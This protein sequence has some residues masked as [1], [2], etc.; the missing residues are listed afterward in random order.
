[1]RR[2]LHT[3]VEL[4]VYNNT[5]QGGG[6]QAPPDSSSSSEVWKYRRK[7]AEKRQMRACVRGGRGGGAAAAAATSKMYSATH[8]PPKRAVE[9]RV[10]LAAINEVVRASTDISKGSDGCPGWARKRVV[11]PWLCCVLRCCSA[12][13]DAMRGTHRLKVL[14]PHP[15][16]TPVLYLSAALVFLRLTL[17]FYCSSAKKVMRKTNKYWV[18][19]YLSKLAGR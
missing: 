15:L 9:V 8:E 19:E 12:A 16:R 4:D 13:L 6:G 1:M 17:F 14:I 18:T 11:S 5:G 3:L 10:K 7:H 2:K